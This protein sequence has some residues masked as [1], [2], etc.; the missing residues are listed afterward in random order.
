MRWYFT[1]NGDECTD[2]GDTT[3]THNETSDITMVSVIHNT[4]DT[5][6]TPVA[7]Y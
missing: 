1:I 5:S 6:L 2:P 7:C 4:I 3:D